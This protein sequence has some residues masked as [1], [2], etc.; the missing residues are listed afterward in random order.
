LDINNSGKY[1]SA[2]PGGQYLPSKNFEENSVLRLTDALTDDLENLVEELLGTPKSRSSRAWRY[3]S[4]GSL[5]VTMS[6]AKRGLYYDH[7]AAEGGGPLQLIMRERGCDFRDAADWARNRL[8]GSLLVSSPLPTKKL[9]KPDPSPEQERLEKIA[10]AQELLDLSEPAAAWAVSYLVHRGINPRRLPGT[11][12]YVQTARIHRKTR[13]I[14]PPAALF[15][16]TDGEGKMQFV[17]RVYLRG[18]EKVPK[19][20]LGYDK[21]TSGPTKG[22]SI[23]FPG[24]ASMPL[25]LAEGPETTL[26]VWIA[27]G[28]E[29][30]ACTGV[31]NLKNQP[32]PPGRPI[33]IAGENY[34]PDAAAYRQTR[35]A[36]AHYQERGHDVRLALPLTADLSDFNDQLLLIGRDSVRRS[37]LDAPLHPPLVPLTP[38]KAKE[39]VV[40]EIGNFLDGRDDV[41]VVGT[42]GTGKTV[43]AAA[44]L[45][46][47]AITDNFDLDYHAPTHDKLREM[48]NELENL[49]VYTRRIMGRSHKPDGENPLC[50][51]AKLAEDVVKL[52]FN[53]ASTLCQN[54]EKKCEHF[55]SCPY[56]HQFHGSATPTVRLYA[57]DYLTLDRPA[58]LIKPGAMIIDETFWQKAIR[59]TE[60]G[61][62]RLIMSAA[63]CALDV[64]TA[65]E[66]SDNPK[67]WLIERGYTAED[68]TEAA[69]ADGRLIDRAPIH[70][71]QDKDTQEKALD[72]YKR[73]DY[74]K[75]RRL[76][77]LIAEEMATAWPYFSK[78]IVHREELFH[79]ELQNRI[80]LHWRVPIR[81]TWMDGTKIPCLI[82][83]ADANRELLELWLPGL[84]IFEVAAKR[85]VEIIQVHNTACSKTRMTGFAS[86]PETIETAKARRAEVQGLINSISAQGKRVLTV[87]TKALAE[88]L[89]A[90]DGSDVAWFGAILGV[91]RWKDCDEEILVGRE[92]APVDA[93][94]Q[95]ASA[96]FWDAKEPLAFVQPDDKGRVMMPRIKRP[97]EMKNGRQMMVDVQIHPDRRAQLVVEQMRERQSIQAIDRIRLV[98]S[99]KKKRVYVLCNVPLPG[100]KPDRVVTWSE[101][102]PKEL[103]QAIASKG[104]LP[105][106]PTDAARGFP[107]IFSSVDSAKWHLKENPAKFTSGTVAVQYQH[108]G[109][110]MKSCR[111]L[112]SLEHPD[113][114]AALESVVGP[115]VYFE[116]EN[117]PIQKEEELMEQELTLDDF[118]ADFN[119]MSGIILENEYANRFD[120]WSLR[121]DD[122][123]DSHDYPPEKRASILQGH[124]EALSILGGSSSAEDN[125]V[126]LTAPLRGKLGDDGFKRFAYLQDGSAGTLTT[127]DA[128]RQVARENGIPTFA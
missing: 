5:V 25:V 79:G 93:Y 34:D 51:K 74:S 56:L 95:L 4:K 71:G 88:E 112:V 62:D 59:R 119:D 49:G 19:D 54:Q 118:Y 7:E 35:D 123:E 128:A 53:P 10:F 69:A 96:L 38:D 125:L 18:D 55:D 67:A 104:V 9:S 46:T 2:D 99:E 126:I 27:T 24:N 120:P 91:D 12:R 50:K 124:R 47:H 105:L 111:A 90:P 98:H 80:S 60:F 110:G 101:V 109:P 44:A 108:S 48:E 14:A 65:F 1:R 11:V 31:H 106:G 83:D 26:S 116:I 117:P 68:F 43:A 32:V 28:L 15:V 16:A 36:V 122:E 66:Q 85:N 113:L 103:D 22:A 127:Q 70:P 8:G 72:G 78:R 40:R 61:S 76:W 42:A 92:Q 87:A 41:A 33:I 63:S 30:W 20:L 17:Q 13:Q 37:I 100:I 58:H 121:L 94:E 75:L 6:G 115:V 57:T 114:K 21:Q 29:C 89:T 77:L 102:V 3:G 39:I 73:N 45:S 81:N 23:K 86:K 52:G 64:R 82:L 84:R 97:L 107:E